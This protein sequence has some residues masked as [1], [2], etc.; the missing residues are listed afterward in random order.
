MTP[1]E[2]MERMG[3]ECWVAYDAS[4]DGD[5]SVLTVG[6]SPEQVESLH[7]LWLY[8]QDAIGDDDEPLPGWEYA[9][10]QYTRSLATDA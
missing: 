2:I 4:D 1:H 7:R 8:E 3:G 5:G 9:V 6:E 10:G